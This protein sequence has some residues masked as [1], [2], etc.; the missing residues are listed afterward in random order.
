MATR[1]ASAPD[2]PTTRTSDWVL[3]FRVDLNQRSL[4]AIEEKKQPAIN[5]NQPAVPLALEQGKPP[6]IRTA[7]KEQFEKA[8]RKTA[9]LHAGLFRR[10]AK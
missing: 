1:S 4:V 9:K 7:T 3:R 8:Q 5:A 10:L 2:D 6:R